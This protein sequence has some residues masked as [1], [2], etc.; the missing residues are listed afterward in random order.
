MATGN[1]WE[2]AQVQE[3]Y[4]PMGRFNH[5]YGK[6][7]FV[8]A[9]FVLVKLQ[10]AL[11]ATWEDFWMPAPFGSQPGTDTE[12]QDYLGADNGDGECRHPFG[13]ITRQDITMDQSEMGDWSA[14]AFE[15]PEGDDTWKMF[16]RIGFI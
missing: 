1:I 3:V 9:P 8:R 5:D 16:H 12:M 6:K 7:R 14:L 13:Y 11:N 2:Q 15:Q 10:P 4:Y